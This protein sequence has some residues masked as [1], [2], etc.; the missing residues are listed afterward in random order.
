L[1]KSVI[2]YILILRIL[3]KFCKCFNL[4]E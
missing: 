4:Q 1:E 3:D 2:A